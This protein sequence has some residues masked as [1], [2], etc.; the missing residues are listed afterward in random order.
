[1]MCSMEIKKIFIE[2]ATLQKMP[3]NSMQLNNMQIMKQICG[4]HCIEKVMQFPLQPETAKDNAHW[5]MTEEA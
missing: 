2:W 4:E 5:S 3:K 1:M